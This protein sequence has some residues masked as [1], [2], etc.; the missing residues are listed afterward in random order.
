MMH[1]NHCTQVF[2]VNPSLPKKRSCLK[3]NL[4]RSNVHKRQ[5]EERI[6]KLSFSARAFTE[7]GSQTLNLSTKKHHYN[8]YFLTLACLDR[9]GESWC[10]VFILR[11]MNLIGDLVH[12]P[13]VTES[14]PVWLCI[15]KPII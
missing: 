10:H 3:D 14:G 7:N 13:G 15:Y 9:N 5:N 12:K 1:V 6:W 11:F 8:K 4:S 2:V